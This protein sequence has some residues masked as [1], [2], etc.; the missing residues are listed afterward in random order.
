MNI[1]RKLII[2]ATLLLSGSALCLGQTSSPT[3]A[4]SPAAA[5]SPASNSPA[6]NQPGF[7]PEATPA[8]YTEGSVWE[9]TMSQNQTAHG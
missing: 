9:I 7:R 6:A 5:S 3:K 4:T 1:A 2:G 8:P